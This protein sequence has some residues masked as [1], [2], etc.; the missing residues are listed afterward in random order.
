MQDVKDRASSN[1]QA[2]IEEQLQSLWTAEDYSG[3]LELL[4][5][6]PYIVDPATLAYLRAI[7]CETLGKYRPAALFFADAARQSEDP[8]VIAALA[9]L[10]LNL[11]AQG[12]IEDAWE[13]ACAQVELFPNAV[14][15]AIASYLRYHQARQAEG[16]AKTALFKEQMIYI[17]RARE[18]YARLPP[19]QQ[20]HPKIKDAIGLGYEAAAHAL[21]LTGDMQGAKKACDAAINFDPSSPNAWTLRG[22]LMSSVEGVIQPNKEAAAAFKKAIDLGDKT[23]APYYFLAFNAL[24]QGGFSE[25]LDWSQQALERMGDKKMDDV[26]STLLQYIGISLDRLG[27]PRAEIEKYFKNAV[28]IASHNIFARSNY[29]HFQRSEPLETPPLADSPTNRLEQS[30]VGFNLERLVIHMPEP[31]VALH[32]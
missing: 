25:A 26:K 29:L 30:E 32:P 24:A 16:D 1:Y 18:E 14:S 20:Q 6:H 31:F 10:P 28:E 7:C 4:Q 5:D 3:I 12:K 11:A 21:Y 22:V 19:A 2:R 9:P 13:Y 15:Y 8:K 27:A 17:E 23:V